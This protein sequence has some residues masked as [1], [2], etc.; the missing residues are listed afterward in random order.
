M[1]SAMLLAKNTDANIFFLGGQISANSNSSLG[2]LALNT[3]N[4]YNADLAIF[5]T[6][7]ISGN[8]ICEHSIEQAAIKKAMIG[9]HNL[10]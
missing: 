7:G 6:S 3:L 9:K 10:K 1:N 5:S 2:C 8:I 4:N